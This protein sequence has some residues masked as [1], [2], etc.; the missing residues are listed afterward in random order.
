MEGF[1]FA[2][3]YNIEFKTMRFLLSIRYISSGFSLLELLTAMVVM[4]ILLAVVIPGFFEIYAKNRI[5]AQSNDFNTAISLAR[6]QA[7]KRGTPV[8]IVRTGSTNGNWDGGYRVFVDKNTNTIATNN[9]EFCRTVGSIGCSPA[10]S[11]CGCPAGDSS[12]EIQ[13]YPALTGN[14]TLRTSS[15]AANGPYQLWIRFD[16]MGVA[17]DKD[18]AGSN[19]GLS[20]EFRLCRS[21]KNTSKSKTISIS[22]VGYPVSKDTVTS[23]P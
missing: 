15:G 4:A 3:R 14:S 11:T 12:C 16:G 17:R 19:T 21:D 9:N 18:S 22:S 1:E 20:G 2:M 23:C 6:N 13:V 8:C 10:S 7:I 5:A